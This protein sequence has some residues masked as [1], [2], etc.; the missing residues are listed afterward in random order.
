MGE[1]TSCCFSFLHLSLFFF[2]L[3]TRL[4]IHIKDCDIRYGSRYEGNYL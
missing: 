2:P 4:H 1:N 3:N